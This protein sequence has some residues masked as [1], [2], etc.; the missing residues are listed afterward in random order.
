[1]RFLKALQKTEVNG[2]RD[3]ARVGDDRASATTLPKLFE[4]K[5]LKIGGANSA[6][7]KRLEA[8]AAAPNA[9]VTSIETSDAGLEDREN[10]TPV[11]RT[12]EIDPESVNPHLVAITH[13]HSTYCEEYRSLRT[14]ILYKNRDRELQSIVVASVGPGEGKSITALNLAWL[15][16]QTEGLTSLIIDSDLRMPSLT[17]YLG[18][19]SSV[20]LS[21]VLND[22]ASLEDSII[23]LKPAGLYLLPGG[24]A[25]GDVAELISGTKFKDLLLDARQLFDYV[26]IDAPPLGIFTDAAILINEADGALLV[27]KANQTLYKDVDRV[28]ASL[29]RKRLM[30]TVLNYSEENKAMDDYYQYPRYKRL[31]TG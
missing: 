12:F 24:E 31:I 14:Q 28:M 21:H 13:P 9:A 16:A 20:G 25:R 6:I 15:L 11:F 1:M 26:I 17:H 5:N 22:K 7:R 18:I 23:E 29:P 10:A 4:D 30:G 19:E 27:V 8:R 2:N 3:A